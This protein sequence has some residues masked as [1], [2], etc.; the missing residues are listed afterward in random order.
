MKIIG[1]LLILLMLVQCETPVQFDEPE[2]IGKNTISTDLP[3]FASTVNS[4]ETVIYFN[5]TTADRSSMQIMYAIKEGGKWTNALDLPFST[6]DYRDVDPFLTHDEN[7]LYFSS[8]RPVDTL[9]TKVFN[10]WYV[11]RFNGSWIGPILSVA[12]LNS[13]ATEIFITMAKNGNAYFVSERDSLRTIVRSSMIDGVYHKTETIE[14][15][16]RGEPLYASNP[17]ISSDENFLIVAAR[18]PQGNGKPDLFVSFNDNGSWT[19]LQNL[20]SRVNSDYAEF[21]PALSKDDQFLYFSSERPGM[22]K[23]QEE[24]TRPPG[25]IY[26]I[27]LKSILVNLME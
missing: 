9:A 12:P 3:E 5:R 11:D 16:L 22:V 4:D 6:G 25:D 23:A 18:D 19:D 7:R 26:K 2:I 17:C 21:A 15:T 10:T 20:G 1:L 24:G 8:D 27:D 13:E 14:L